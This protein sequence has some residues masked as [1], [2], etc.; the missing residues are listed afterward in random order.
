[1]AAAA[2][3]GDD[4]VLPED[5][6]A[7]TA[8]AIGKAAEA[9]VEKAANSEKAKGVRQTERLEADAKKLKERQ[10]HAMA[11]QTQQNAHML[12]MQQ[13]QAQQQMQMMQMMQQG[14]GASAGASSSSGGGPSAGGGGGGD[15]MAQLEKLSAKGCGP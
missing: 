4:S 15:L 14:A 1:M 12:A 7:A 11:M 8:G 5:P 2:G 10:D 3:G 6:F 13:Q 9:S